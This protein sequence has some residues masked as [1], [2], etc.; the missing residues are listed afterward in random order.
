[1]LDGK[2]QNLS[3]QSCNILLNISFDVGRGTNMFEF[4]KFYARMFSSLIFKLK[5][6]FRDPY[7]VFLALTF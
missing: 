4:V 7:A 6:Y 3:W 5:K 2:Q 1:M